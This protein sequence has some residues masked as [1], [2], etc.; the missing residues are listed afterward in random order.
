[1]ARIAIIGM[2]SVGRAALKIDSGNAAFELAA[3]NDLLSAELLACL[4]KYETV[5]G[6]LGKPVE[7]EKVVLHIDGRPCPVFN[8]KEPD[9]RRRNGGHRHAKGV[10]WPSPILGKGRFEAA[11]RAIE[12]LAEALDS[13]YNPKT[14]ERIK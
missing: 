14:A 7:A 9:A 8:E 3:V 4:L 6:R 12:E 5:T 11:S 2:G 13:I 1:M 10:R